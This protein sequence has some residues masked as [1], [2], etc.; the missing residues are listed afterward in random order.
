LSGYTPPTTGDTDE[1]DIPARTA[2]SRIVLRPTPSLFRV[3]P[4]RPSPRVPAAHR[5]ELRQHGWQPV[6]DAE[7]RKGTGAVT[8]GRRRVVGGGTGECGGGRGC[9]GVGPAVAR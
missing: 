6:S 5:R 4:A 7:A 9:E 2:T 1:A 8:G 3:I